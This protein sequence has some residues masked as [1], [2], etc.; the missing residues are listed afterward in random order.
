MKTVKLILLS[1]VA[2][3]LLNVLFSSFDLSDGYS[4]IGFPF[5]YLNYASD[6]V[7]IVTI[8]LSLVI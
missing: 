5:R 6:N 1:L 4:M 2:F 3:V 8:G 7:V